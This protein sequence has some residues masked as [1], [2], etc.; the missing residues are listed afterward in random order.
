[1][2]YVYP[3]VFEKEGN[4]GYSVS[5]PDLEG[6]FTCGK[7]LAEALFMAEDCLGLVL[8]GFQ[9]DKEEFPA[10][11]DIVNFKNTRDKFTSL[12]SVDMKE[13]R[14]RVDSKPVRKTLYIPKNLNEQA[15]AIGINFSEVLRHALQRRVQV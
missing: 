7:D 1:M 12:I 3:A 15:E 11:S 13:Y 14:K 8:Y 9:E 2:K 4:G 10:P 5:C 6:A